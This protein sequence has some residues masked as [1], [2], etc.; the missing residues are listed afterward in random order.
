MPDPGANH[1]L[2]PITTGF[3]NDAV[4]PDDFLGSAQG[5]CFKARVLRT[6]FDIPPTK[7]PEDLEAVNLDGYTCP[8]VSDNGK[9]C[10]FADPMIFLR[11]GV[12][13]VAMGSKNVCTLESDSPRDFK[14]ASIG[15][16]G[17]RAVRL[18]KQLI[19]FVGQKFS[20]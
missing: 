13:F 15:S 12:G 3:M 14:K 18:G 19:A 5:E 6:A 11:H 1:E 16:I 10:T 17:V 2:S 20:E 8:F 4:V 9:E 7:I